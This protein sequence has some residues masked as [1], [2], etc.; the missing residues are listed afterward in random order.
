VRPN[1]RLIGGGK[2]ATS[3]FYRDSRVRS[4]AILIFV[5][6]AAC[7]AAQDVYSTTTGRLMPRRDRLDPDQ[8]LQGNCAGLTITTRTH[9]D[10]LRQLET[11]AKE[12][13]NAPPPTLQGWF[14]QRPSALEASKERKRLAQLN[15]ALDAHGCKTMDV[16][17]ELKNPTPLPMPKSQK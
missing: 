8:E 16:G 11:K 5:P 12:E 3:T 14:E 6:V 17:A 13:Q 1:G 7:A 2:I 9:I 4:L 10:H 15:A